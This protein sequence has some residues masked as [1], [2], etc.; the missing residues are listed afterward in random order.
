VTKFA[1][2]PL[3]W[4]SLENEKYWSL[5]LNETFFG[6]KR[7]HPSVT[8]VIVDS[9]TS[10]FLIPKGNPNRLFST[11]DFEEIASQFRRNYSN[12][13]YQPQLKNMFA[14]D[15]THRQF[16]RYPDFKLII[17]GKT[18]FIP[19]SNYISKVRRRLGER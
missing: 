5:H 2:E 10:F 12:C 7:L 8:S 15:C 18:Y 14:C 19:S 13:A 1:K 3:T 16:S 9:G 4:H 17:D 11:E 6:T